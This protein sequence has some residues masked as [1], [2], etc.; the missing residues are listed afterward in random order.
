MTVSISVSCKGF[1]IFLW[2]LSDTKNDKNVFSQGD[3]RGEADIILSYD[4]GKRG[5]SK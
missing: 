4:F 5:N 3:I 2:P 1:V